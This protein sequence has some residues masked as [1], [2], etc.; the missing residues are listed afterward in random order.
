[1]AIESELAAPQLLI[2]VPH[3]GDANFRRTVVLVLDHGDQGTMGLTINRPGSLPMGAFCAGQSM[4]FAGDPQKRVFQGGPVQ[5]DRAFILHASEHQGPETEV[6]FDS[7]R[8]SYSL[9]SLRIIAQ[10]PPARFRVYLGYAGWA[11]RQLAAEV[12][13]GAWLVVS[14]SEELVLG[15]EAGEIW[16]RALAREGIAAVQ[17]VP[18]SGLH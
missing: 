7:V 11:P 18:S 5:T 14:P 9:E 17:L 4:P 8:L 12:H 10:A 15:T 13:A 16:D 6:V 2:A 1:M 3:L